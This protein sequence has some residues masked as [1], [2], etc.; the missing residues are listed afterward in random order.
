VVDEV[1]ATDLG[2]DNL[3]LEN[4]SPRAD[5]TWTDPQPLL[6]RHLVGV[7]DDRI[8]KIS[9]RNASDLFRHSVPRDRQP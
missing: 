5:S 9:W 6:Q 7:S 8:E 4:D 1:T 2:V 3:V